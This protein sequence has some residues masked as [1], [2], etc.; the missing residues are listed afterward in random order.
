MAALRAGFHRDLFRN[1]S[2]AVASLVAQQQKQAPEAG[3]AAAGQERGPVPFASPNAQPARGRDQRGAAERR[4]VTEKVVA[5]LSLLKHL[6]L[7]SAP[8]KQLL[9]RDG[10]VALLR[11][12]WPVAAASST[13]GPLFHELLGFLNNLL[14]DCAEA[15]GR[16]AHEGASG[17]HDAACAPGT[18]LG[19]LMGALFGAGKLEAPTFNL[20]VGVL[21]QLS[22][23]EDGVQQLLRGPFLAAC[24]KAL[25]DMA[26]AAGGGAGAP[27]ALRL[28]REPSRQAALLQVLANVAGWPE[29]QRAL[30]RSASAAGLLELVMR[31]VDSNP[32]AP[33]APQ[34]Q[35]H[36]QQPHQQQGAL[37]NAALALLRNLCFAPEAKAHLLAHP[38]VLPALVAAAEAV[39]DN[40][41][42]AAYASSGLW[43]LVHQ[44]EKVKA[45]LRRVP[46]A[47]QRLVAAWAACRFQEARAGAQPKAA[48]PHPYGQAAGDVDG[49]EH[50]GPAAARAL[51][52]GTRAIMYG[53]YPGM[54]GMGRYGPMGYGGGRVGGGNKGGGGY[55]PPKPKMPK[56][57][58][59]DGGGG[60]DNGGGWDPYGG[61]GMGGFDMGGF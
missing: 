39:S 17:E 13:S 36:Q 35:P 8:A 18:L 32:R 14:P 9:V 51:H 19:S 25:L 20:A 23:P 12:L 4:L 15:R 45:A 33:A 43:A 46:S 31:L 44:G 11:S 27:G 57:D 58:W 38:G 5:A 16:T 21:L 22:A 24:V 54:P 50:V 60:Q 53:M 61:M 40:P 2:K 29:G 3:T 48:Q 56:P 52:N 34:A 6:A 55:K 41:E 7:G 42:G 47:Q 1:C 26:N 28:G 30:L 49:M 10:V 59:E 37:R